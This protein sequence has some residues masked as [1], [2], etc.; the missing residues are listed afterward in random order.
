MKEK[1]ETLDGSIVEIDSYGF[2]GRL[3]I[4]SVNG[5]RCVWDTATGQCWGKEEWDLKEQLNADNSEPA[6]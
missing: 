2:N 1:W 3:K 6:R 4:G 5:I